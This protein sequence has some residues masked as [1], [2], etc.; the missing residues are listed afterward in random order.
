[1]TCRLSSKEELWQAYGLPW[2]LRC[3]Q[4]VLLCVVSGSGGH[5]D[6]W[7]CAFWQLGGSKGCEPG[8]R[9]LNSLVT[10]LLCALESGGGHRDLGPHSPV[11]PSP[12]SVAG[13]PGAERAE[14]HHLV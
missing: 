1:M 9:A 5:E 3:R 7:G 4:L 10:C 6:P 2:Q 8:P 14:G 12:G 11:G 13:L